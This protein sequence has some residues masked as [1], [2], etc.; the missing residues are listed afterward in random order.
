MYLPLT[1]G[2]AEWWLTEFED[3]W[4]YTVAPA[5]VYFSRSANQDRLTRPPVTRFVATPYPTDATAYA[6]AA[7]MIVPPLWIRL[8]RRPS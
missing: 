2:P 6:L 4:P 5:D 8:R 7:V 3:E 1:T